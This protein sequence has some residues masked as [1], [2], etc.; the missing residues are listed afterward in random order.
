M[1]SL[2]CSSKPSLASP[3]RP[4]SELESSLPLEAAL[5][6]VPARSAPS[7]AGLVSRHDAP[8]PSPG[9]PLVGPS[10]HP[11]PRA[12][13]AILRS[14]WPRFCQPVLWGLASSCSLGPQAACIAC[15]MRV[16][17]WATPSGLTHPSNL[18]FPF[19]LLCFRRPSFFVPYFSS[20]F[21]FAL[22]VRYGRCFS[23]VSGHA[24]AHSAPPCTP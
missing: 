3:F 16:K 12:P 17:G 2:W 23:A 20:C 1:S 14:R 8:D 15:C 5:V 22:A 24:V 11:P 21:S 6:S 4:R 10:S 19:L 13:G 9:A 7:D 18:S